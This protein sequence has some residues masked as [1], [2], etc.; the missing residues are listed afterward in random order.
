M[1]VKRSVRNL[2]I[3][4]IVGGMILYL[5]FSTSRQETDTV[6]GRLVIINWDDYLAPDVLADFEKE[7][8]I[9][10]TIIEYRTVDESISLIQQNPGAY[11]LLIV[12]ESLVEFLRE[13]ELVS[14]FEKEHLEGV[15]RIL[16]AFSSKLPWAIPYLWSTTGFAVDRRQI[17]DD[18]DSIAILWDPRYRGRIALLDDVRESVSPALIR[19]GISINSTDPR[20]IAGIEPFA[21]ELAENGIRFGDTW[22]NIERLRNGEVWIAHTYN[23]DYLYKLNGDDRF[24]FFLPREG[25]PT[26]ADFFMLPKGA[27]NPAAAYRFVSFYLRPE[28]AAKNSNRYCYANL[29][30]GSDRFLRPDLRDNPT[31]FPPVE[32]R[33]RGIAYREVGVTFAA[34]QRIFSLM[35]Q[36]VRQ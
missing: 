6:R 35:K 18:A 2:V 16:P 9:G 8:G 23:G 28:I 36:S 31:V 10:V 5:F 4:A 1:K 12:N 7:T 13:A 20:Q 11:D 33:S 21:R 14:P 34:Y 32:V 19:A 27:Q 26:S 17:P 15:D 3:F 30:V 25:F 22:D 24:R 29:V